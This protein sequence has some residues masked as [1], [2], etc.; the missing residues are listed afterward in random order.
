MRA[1]EHSYLA[2]VQVSL[3]EEH[4]RPQWLPAFCAGHIAP[5]QGCCAV[6][7]FWD[8]AS[9]QIQFIVLTG[10]PFGLSSAVLNFNRTPALL[11]AVA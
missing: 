7:A 2:C 1:Q 3:N 4:Q 5:D 11:T 8:E 6:A 10:L 9:E